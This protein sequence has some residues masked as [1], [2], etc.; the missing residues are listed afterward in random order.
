MTRE[1]GEFELFWGP[2][3][4]WMLHLWS[5]EPFAEKYLD[6]T[7]EDERRQSFEHLGQFS[8]GLAKLTFPNLRPFLVERLLACKLF[9]AHLASWLNIDNVVEI[10]VYLLCP[11]LSPPEQWQLRPLGKHQDPFQRQLERF[12][13]ALLPWPE[14]KVSGRGIRE[15]AEAA[16]WLFRRVSPDKVTWEDVRRIFNVLFPPYQAAYPK[17]HEMRARLAAEKLPHASIEELARKFLQGDLTQTK[18]DD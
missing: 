12:V 11:E 15:A 9:A 17:L 14:D 8:E 1:Q 7:G 6:M 5:V 3:A 4:A 18:T 10:W 2:V 16:S 13:Q